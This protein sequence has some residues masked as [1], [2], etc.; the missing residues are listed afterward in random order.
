MLPQPVQ[1]CLNEPRLFAVVS[2]GLP[3]GPSVLTDTRA[4]AGTPDPHAVISQFEDDLSWLVTLTFTD[5]FVWALAEPAL[6]T[7]K[8]H[9]APTMS[10]IDRRLVA[11]GDSFDRPLFSI[12]KWADAQRPSSY[13][14]FAGPRRLKAGGS[15]LDVLTV[16][17]GR[18]R[19]VGA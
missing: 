3:L 4:P 16:L 9:A 18:P 10:A 19:L 14:V 15:L 11:D 7:S 2:L 6:M 1:E 12:A 17:E 8:A 13:A 5:S